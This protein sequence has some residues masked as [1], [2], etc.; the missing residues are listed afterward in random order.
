[1]MLHDGGLS[2]TST[3][4]ASIRYI[5]SGN[6]LS[7]TR[8]ENWTLRNIDCGQILSRFLVP[9]V[10][11]LGH[12]PSKLGTMFLIPVVLLPVIIGSIY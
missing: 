11:S 9:I 4:S 5:S 1:M 3:P 7:S 10:L 6:R 8:I 2:D 12:S